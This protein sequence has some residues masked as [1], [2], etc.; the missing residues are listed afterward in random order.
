[1][2]GADVSNPYGNQ[3]GPASAPAP[4]PGLRPGWNQTQQQ[5]SHQ[6][7]PPQPPWQAPSTQVMPAVEGQPGPV[8]PGHQPGQHWAN[9]PASAQQ[10]TVMAPVG[11]PPG[12]SQ[13]LP[14]N[15]AQGFHQQYGQLGQG[16]P[17]Q[18]Y[19]GDGGSG[20]KT[21]LWVALGCVLALLVVGAV[22]IV[23][24][25]L[26]S[27]NDRAGAS[28]STASPSGLVQPQFSAT[29]APP[30]PATNTSLATAS[31]SSP[32][33]E[34]SSPSVSV[35]TTD[36]STGQATSSSASSK[37]T[38]TVSF[39]TLASGFVRQSEMTLINT[40]TGEAIS[41]GSGSAGSKAGGQEGLAGARMVG[42]EFL[43]AAGGTTFTTTGQ[44]SFPTASGASVTAFYGEAALAGGKFLVVSYVQGGQ[45]FAIGYLNARGTY[46][47]AKALALIKTARVTITS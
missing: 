23:V 15:P 9:Q 11:A 28:T 43:D 47:Q 31:V 33:V 26:T 42:L 13:A 36:S 35:P 40:T 12:F 3:P 39:P 38:I 46:D 24:W 21:A 27:R 17:G 25:G 7:P 10:T 34:S 5:P 20:S 22:G 2:K 1:M 4:Q 41:Y 30:A 6:Q 32:V 29:V 14:G 45:S 19:S 16:Y 18:G 37:L 8:Q 44:T